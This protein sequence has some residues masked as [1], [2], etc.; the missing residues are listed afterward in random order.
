MTTVP[1]LAI[2]DMEQ[3]HTGLTKAIADSCAEA[4]SVCLDRHHEPPTVFDLDASGKQS[5]ATVRWPAPDERTRRAWANDIDATEF[6]A[7]ACILAAIELAAGRVAVRRAE[8]MTG[9]DYYVACP[10]EAAD[11]LENCLRLEIS[12]VDRGSLAT[13]TRRLAQKLDQLARG[14]GNLPAMAGVVG[15]EARAILLAEHRA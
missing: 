7:Y 10:G 1:A 6:G 3:R 11:D 8:T 5:S 15:F 13:A 12:G 9:A 4:A 2:R 14:A